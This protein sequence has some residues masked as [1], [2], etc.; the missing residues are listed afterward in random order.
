MGTPVVSCELGSPGGRGLCGALREVMGSGIC[1][2]LGPLEVPSWAPPTCVLQPEAACICHN[3]RY[4]SRT[5][6]SFFKL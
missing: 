6:F 4:F 1:H 5:V 2:V 3:T